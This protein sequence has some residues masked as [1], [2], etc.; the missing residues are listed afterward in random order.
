MSYVYVTSEPG[1][2]SVGFYD[3]RGKWHGDSDHTSRESA[4]KRVH[5]LNGGTDDH[6]QRAEDE[7]NYNR[8]IG[9]SLRR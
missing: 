7:S 5:Y 2:L 1:L 4:A 9:D 8:M 6:D 3:P